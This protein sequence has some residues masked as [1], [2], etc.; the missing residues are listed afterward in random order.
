M[1]RGLS[2]L[3]PGPHRA[4]D[5]DEARTLLAAERERIERALADVAAPLDPELSGTD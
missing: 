5:T 3:P 2:P 1:P 4:M